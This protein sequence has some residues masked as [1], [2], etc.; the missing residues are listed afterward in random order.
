MLPTV[1][2]SRLHLEEYAGVTFKLT[3]KWRHRHPTHPRV[4][5]MFIEAVADCALLICQ[6]LNF[7]WMYLFM[8]L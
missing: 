5:R 7:F 6:T 3:V 2:V 1:W 4:G 8:S